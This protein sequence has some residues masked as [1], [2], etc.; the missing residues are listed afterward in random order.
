[1]DAA[2]ARM[3]HPVAAPAGR[4]SSPQGANP[5]TLNCN[6]LAAGG[7]RGPAPPGAAL[8]MRIRRATPA[9][10]IE[11]GTA[12]KPHA[13]KSAALLGAALSLCAVAA[14]ATLGGA[15]ASVETDRARVGARVDRI[16]HPAYTVHQ[17]TTAD[18]GIVR[19]YVAADG[20]VFGVSWNGP[21]KPDLRQLLGSH[22]DTLGA[23]R[24]RVSGGRAHLAIREGAL[25]FESNGRM[26]SFHG[27]AFL[28]DA[29]PAGVSSDEIQ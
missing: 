15:V 29:L 26:R 25:V 20:V 14:H 10:A 18:G 7:S 16:A 11:K 6:K 2:A 23:S 9:Q 19:E 4:R 13:R 21:A 27:R 3:W 17:L 12:V 24:N 28:N 22:F 1:M 5:V 8:S